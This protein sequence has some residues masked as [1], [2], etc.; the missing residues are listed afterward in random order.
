MPEGKRKVAFIGTGVMGA[1]MAGHLLAAGHPLTVYNR[2]R[3]RD[4]SLVASGAQW[5]DTPAAAARNADIVITIVGFPSDVE[6]VYFGDDGILEAAKPGAV[7]VDMTTSRPDLAVRI[8]EEAAGRGMSA[9][10]APVSG[11]DVGAREARLSIMVGGSVE[12]FDSV[13]PLLELMGK[14]I[15]FQGPCGSG[16]HTKMCNQ[17]AIAAGMLGVV[18]AIVYAE[19]SGLDP[20]TVLKSIGSGAAGSWSLANLAPRII[21]R[22]FAPGIYVK[23]FIKDLS[24]AL[25]SARALGL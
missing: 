5:A 11:G 17:I 20:A 25:E 7:L 12:A 15:V 9:L 16:Q 2:T 19:K 1:S 13:R 24:I 14:N 10:D 21:D 23:H 4:D 22:N 3:S 18:E 6:S 8:G